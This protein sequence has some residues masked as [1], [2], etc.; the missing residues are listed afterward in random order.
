MFR[1]GNGKFFFR[2]VCQTINGIMPG[3]GT[4]QTDAAFNH[5]AA[6]FFP[7]RVIHLDFFGILRIQGQKLFNTLFKR[8]P[9]VQPGVPFRRA[10]MG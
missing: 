9:F 1:P 5:I 7:T 10:D 8:L 2:P 6:H 4:Q 3:G